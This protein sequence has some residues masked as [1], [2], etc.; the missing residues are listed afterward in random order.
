M[1]ELSKKH[2][3]YDGYLKALLP[4]FTAESSTAKTPMEKKRRILRKLGQQST[5][6]EEGGEE[7]TPPPPPNTRKETLRRRIIKNLKDYFCYGVFFLL[8]N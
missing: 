3:Q 5:T 7:D 4:T 2:Y 8:T 6:E 1:G